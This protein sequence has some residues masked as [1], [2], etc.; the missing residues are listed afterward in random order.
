MLSA[1]QI[2]LVVGDNEKTREGLLA[3]GVNLKSVELLISVFYAADREPHLLI[4][5]MVF[6]YF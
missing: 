1:H 2:A 5:L 4:N 6:T 3:H